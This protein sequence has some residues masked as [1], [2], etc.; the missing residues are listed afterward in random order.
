MR[1]ALSSQTVSRSRELLMK[2]VISGKKKKFSL[3]CERRE[4]IPAALSPIFDYLK[5]IVGLWFALNRVGICSDIVVR[6]VE[7]QFIVVTLFI[8]IWLLLYMFE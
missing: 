5:A 6:C 8:I 7:M 1:G 4:G 3:R 2:G